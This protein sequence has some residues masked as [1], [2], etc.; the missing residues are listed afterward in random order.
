MNIQEFEE[1][2]KEDL[3]KPIKKKQLTV[4]DLK[5]GQRFK[6]V[7]VDGVEYRH[8]RDGLLNRIFI[9]ARSATNKDDP[10]YEGRD[11]LLPIREENSLE[12]IGFFYDRPIEL[13]E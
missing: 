9:A 6:F 3:P 12:A 10:L 5:E 8:N 11:T 2:C 13:V 1:F 4:G 7:Q